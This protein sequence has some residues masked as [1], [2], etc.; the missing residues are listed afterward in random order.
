[1][2]KEL[3]FGKINS[4][5]KSNKNFLI[6]DLGLKDIIDQIFSEYNYESV[7]SQPDYDYFISSLE[8]LRRTSM[9]ESYINFRLREKFPL[10][11]ESMKM[12]KDESG[13]WHPVNKLNTN[14]TQQ[15]ELLS[16][17]VFRGYLK[18]NER[19]LEIYNKIIKDPESGLLELK[20]FLKRLIIKY[21]IEEGEGLEDFKKQ[22]KHIEFM[23]AIG[24]REEL[25]IRKILEDFGY[26][27]LYPNT[28]KDGDYIDMVFGCDMIVWREDHGYK[29][30]Q[31]KASF[32]GWGYIS[33]Y[34]VDWISFNGEFWDLSNRTRIDVS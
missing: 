8:L 12:V 10:G 21:F 4:F 18:N 16:E 34:K 33:R 6:Y 13:S 24:L 27:I 17:L 9:D 3:L 2:D 25:R 14:Y 30:L 29:T 11:K 26:K 23:S 22:T 7:I 28:V 1:M 5:S 15:A 32:T 20:P 19:G 31:V